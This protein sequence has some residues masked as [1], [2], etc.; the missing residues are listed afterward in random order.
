MRKRR[1]YWIL[2]AIVLVVANIFTGCSSTD[3]PLNGQVKFHDIEVT[4]EES[5]VRDSTRSTDDFWVFEYQNFKEY[6]LLSRR[7][8][9]GDAQKGL[10]D[11]SGYM[12]E[13]GVECETVNFAW[14]D[15]VLSTYTNEEDEYCQEIVFAYEGSYYAIALRK[16]T[17]E[18]FQ[19]LVD[20]VVLMSSEES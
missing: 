11:Y 2:F 10:E 12:K 14:G 7:G 6:I 1:C 9:E 13:E 17:K 19:T 8:I 3:M 16:G 5:F 4:I 20:S 18:R 15:A